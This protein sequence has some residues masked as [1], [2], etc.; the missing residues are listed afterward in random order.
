MEHSDLVYTQVKYEDGH[1]VY[2]ITN[3]DMDDTFTF[4][5]SLDFKVHTLRRNTYMT[6]KVEEFGVVVAEE[7]KTIGSAEDW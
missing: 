6:V 4:V 1:T 2:E 7:T 5:F 3:T